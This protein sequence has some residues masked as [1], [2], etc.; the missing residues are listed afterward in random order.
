MNKFTRAAAMAT[1][2]LILLAGAV[3]VPFVLAQGGLSRQPLEW[4]IAKQL[5]VEGYITDRPIALRLQDVKDDT[6]GNVLAETSVSTGTTTITSS[7][8]NPD[9]PRNLQ[10]T[11]A[12]DTNIWTAVRTA[13]NV[14]ITGVDARGN[15]KVEVLAMTAISSTEALTGSVPFATITNFQIPAQSFQISMTVSL[16][17]KFGLPKSRLVATSDVYFFT[18]NNTYSSNVTVDRTNATVAPSSVS[19]ND[20]LTIWFKQ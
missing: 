2:S 6:G 4:A 20:D 18:V 3:I 19:A 12:Q 7:I 13:G 16:G 8:T 10:I 5:S 1:L 9:F 15:A 17:K 14:L 11:L